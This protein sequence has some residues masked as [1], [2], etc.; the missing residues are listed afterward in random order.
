MFMDKTL[1][2]VTDRFRVVGGF[3]LA[4]I[5]A[6]YQINLIIKCKYFAMFKS[7]EDKLEKITVFCSKYPYPVIE[8]SQLTH[9]VHRSRTCTG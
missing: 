6:Q 7:M 2:M 4:N 1:F 5:F 8:T 9:F 3:Y